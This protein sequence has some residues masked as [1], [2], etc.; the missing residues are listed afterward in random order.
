MWGGRLPD[1]RSTFFFGV[2]MT[3][4]KATE[5]INGQTEREVKLDLFELFMEYFE[6]KTQQQIKLFI[7]LCG[8]DFN[9]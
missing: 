8:Y 3:I 1:V 9:K 5:I 4:E 6:F 7:D 2:N